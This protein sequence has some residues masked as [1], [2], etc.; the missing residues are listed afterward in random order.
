V[1]HIKNLMKMKGLDE[2]GLIGLGIPFDKMTAETYTKY[3][4]LLRDEPFRKK[5]NGNE[6]DVED[7]PF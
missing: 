5:P 6:V 1:N 3:V 4:R 2:A 7:I